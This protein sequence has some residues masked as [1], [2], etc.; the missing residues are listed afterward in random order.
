M[1]RNSLNVVD[2]NQ[3]TPR[4]MPCCN[5]CIERYYDNCDN[6]LVLNWHSEAINQFEKDIRL[7]LY[8]V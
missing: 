3:P 4:L 7:V 8:K 2:L 6:C 5:L 1:I